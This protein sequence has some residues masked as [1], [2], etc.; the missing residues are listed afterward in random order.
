MTPLDSD[1]WDKTFAQADKMRAAG[2]SERLIDVFINKRIEMEDNAI[3][4]QRLKP[5]DIALRLLVV[6]ICL[7]A[8]VA[9]AILI[10]KIMEKA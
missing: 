5:L 4:R 2:K 3:K 6:A 7:K 9:V 8:A 10:S 1:Y